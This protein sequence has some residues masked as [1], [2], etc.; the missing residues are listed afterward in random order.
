MYVISENGK[1]I[2]KDSIEVINIEIDG[3]GVVTLTA[4]N[5]WFEIELIRFK[6]SFTNYDFAKKAIMT[7]LYDSMIH[8]R[9]V[10]FRDHEPILPYKLKGYDSD[11]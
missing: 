10:D 9:V 2:K 11:K 1:L 8:T 5:N 3:N 4:K 7:K 6:T